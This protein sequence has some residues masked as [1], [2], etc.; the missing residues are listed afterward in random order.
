MG[1]TFREDYWKKCCMKLI[2]VTSHDNYSQSYALLVNWY[3]N[4]LLPL[5]RQF[6]LIPNRINEFFAH[7]Q[8][9]NTDTDAPG[10]Q[11]SSA[12][13]AVPR[14]TGRLPPIVLTCATNLIQLQKQMKGVAKQTFEFRS[15]KNGTRVATK[16]IVECQSV[17]A[18][19]ETNNI[20]YYTFYPKSEK[21]ITAVIHHLSASLCSFLQPLVISSLPGPNILLSI[22][23]SNT[24]S[25]CSSLSETKLHTHIEPQAVLYILVMRQ[26]HK[27]FWSEW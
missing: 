6:F 10:T 23:F 4:R 21:L 25:L 1:L 18:Y 24:L 5:I 13:E 15:T 27:R 3:N 14:K 17:K 12:E 16:N 20:S 9:T 2:A 11:P 19:F 7:L 8:T 22:L 26:E